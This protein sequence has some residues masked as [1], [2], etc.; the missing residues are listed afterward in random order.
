MAY[1]SSYESPEIFIKWNFLYSIA[2][3]LGRKVWFQEGEPIYPNIFVIPVAAPGIGK[4]MPAKKF[5]S[6]LSSLTK[7]DSRGQ[8]QDLVNIAPQVVTLERLYEVLE[9]CGDAVQRKDSQGN[10]LLKPDGKLAPPYFH[11]SASFLL[12]D[13]LGMLL[14]K[15][16]QMKNIVLF[17]N[18]GY[19]CM[20][21]FRY[22]TKRN[23]INV[24][25]NLCI[26]FFGCCTPDWVSENVSSGLI[27]N[28]FSS[29]IFWIWGEEKRQMTTFYKFSEEQN[30][31]LEE[32]KNH[33]RA[34]AQLCGPVNFSEEAMEYFENWYQKES[35]KD[36]VNKD[37]KLDHYYARKKIHF[38]K[39][40]ILAH[41]M[42]NSSSMVVGLN[43]V[44]Q[45]RKWLTEAELD[46]HKAL[47]SVN[48]NPIARMAAD[49]FRDVKA[50]GGMTRV[51]FIAKYFTNGNIPQID[52]AIN[53]LSVTQQITGSP[54][55]RFVL[56]RKV[57]EGVD[58]ASGLIKQEE[59]IKTQAAL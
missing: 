13:E 6:L 20:D 27:D 16:D 18:G 59:P 41:F 43:S 5:A 39:I 25:N 31:L 1:F 57:I 9:K 53:F 50:K 2:S 46:M 3:C 34:I 42:E 58:F 40:S 22:E 37:G 44:K 28:G 23:G 30:K 11:S 19:D 56:T 36:R 21:K 4:S 47:A 24:V 49:M 33:F 15:S 7:L 38:V 17:L 54:G 26:N 45:A 29:R 48:Q 51:E 35:V 8:L 12:A 32:L 10:P 14:K 52:E 55:G